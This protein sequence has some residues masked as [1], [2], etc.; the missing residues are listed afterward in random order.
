MK[1]QNYQNHTR[2]FAFHHFVLTPLTL[3]FLGWTVNKASFE[4]SESTSESIYSLILALILVLLPLLARI[5][6]LKN[7]NR[8]ILMEMRMRYFNLTG[9]SFEE[10]EK[11][12]K[13]GQIIALRFAGD[14]ELLDLIER[15]I[16]KKL[17]NKEI[18]ISVKDWRGDYSRV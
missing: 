5:Y 10:K 16:E 7:Q 14:A 1:T 17:S 6:A 8:I 11:M 4:T 13:T 3:I 9:K 12:L 15:A 2:Y 18:K